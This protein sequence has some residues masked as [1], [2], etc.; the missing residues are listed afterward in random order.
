MTF[1]VITMVLLVALIAVAFLICAH[2]ISTSSIDLLRSRFRRLELEADL[3]HWK[4]LQRKA[5]QEIFRLNREI[6][7]FEINDKG[8][9]PL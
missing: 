7:N 8:N 4:S 9:A 5:T 3:A 1:E 6:E 2:W